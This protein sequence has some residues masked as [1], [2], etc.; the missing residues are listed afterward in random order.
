MGAEA[1]LQNTA[2]EGLNERKII[3]QSED[4]IAKQGFLGK[5]LAVGKSGG[6]VRLPGQLLP[7]G[8]RHHRRFPRP[9]G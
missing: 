2:R 7:V 9:P 3:L 8:G 6:N 4:H 5:L 1:D